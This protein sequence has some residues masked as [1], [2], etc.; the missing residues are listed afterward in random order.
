MSKWLLW[1]FLTLLTGSPL[2][3]LGLVIVFIFVA[4]RFTWR[5]LPSPVRMMKRFQRAG[6]LAGTILTNPHERRAR[7]ELADIRVEQ[8]RYEEAVDILKP[9]LEA[10]DEDVDTL[11]LLGV[12]YLG[13][14][15][16]QRGELLLDEAAKLDA[17]YR[18][19]AI[20]LERGRFRLKRGE[21]KG[22]IE[23]LERFCATRLGSVEGRY[24]LARALA[25]DGRS[26]DAKRA[27]DAAWNEYVVAPGFQR[28][29]ERRWAWL[30]RPSRPLTYAV[31]LALVL[32]TGATMA[33]QMGLFTQ[34]THR[35]G[36]GYGEG[37]PPGEAPSA[38]GWEEA[39]PPIE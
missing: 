26:A 5:L 36:G 8:K 24:L 29:R 33:R 18:Q 9:N 7:H 28:R 10:G 39:G 11:F 32:G 16:A 31:L 23:A 30:S 34:R 2:L 22:A 35:Y 3:S 21:V 19:G 12:A 6:Y 1:M 15:D 17:G 38:A 25:K 37:Y 4:D 14:G 27:R 20:D 13:A